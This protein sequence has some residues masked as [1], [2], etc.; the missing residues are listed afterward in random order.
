M[1][2]KRVSVKHILSILTVLVVLCTL[3]TLAGCEQGPNAVAIEVVED[4]VPDVATIGSFDLSQLKLRITDETGNTQEIAVT[5]SMLDTDSRNSLKEPG[6]KNINVFY[7]GCATT[8]NIFLVEEG[9][10][11]VSV[12]F[13]ARDFTQIAKKHTVANGSIEAPQAPSIAGMVFDCW[14]NK[15][16]S[17]EASFTNITS[18]LIVYA[19]YVN[20]ENAAKY[21]VTFRDYTNQVI[22]I[23]EIPYNKTIIESGYTAPGWEE[24]ADIESWQWNWNFSTDRV[25]QNTNINMTVTY[26]SRTIAFKY[27]YSTDINNE[28]QFPLTTSAT[29]RIGS[30]PT[31]TQLNAAKAEL[32]QQ[33]KQFVSWV[34]M[35]AVRTNTSNILFALVQ[36]TNYTVSFT[37]GSNETASVRSGISYTMPTNYTA[38]PGYSFELKWKDAQG[39]IYNAG[40]SYVINGNLALTPVYTPEVKNAQFIFSFVGLADPE[41]ESEVLTYQLDR[42][43]YYD[44]VIRRDYIAGLLDQL[45]RSHTEVYDY[46]IDIIKYFG[47]TVTGN[48]QKIGF[49]DNHVFEITCVDVSM[50]SPG[51]SFTLDSVRNGYV[52][53]GYTPTDSESALN[54]I[55][56]ETYDGLPVIGIADGVFGADVQGV[57]LTMSISLPDG[58][59]FI[60]ENA[61]EGVT[62][63]SDV[64]IPGSLVEMGKEAFLNA[65]GENIKVIFR[66]SVPTSINEI[67]ESAFKSFAGLK[68]VVLPRNVNIIG[69]SAFAGCANLTK[70][71]LADV[72]TIGEA[73]FEGCSALNDIG[74]LNTVG[75]VGDYAFAGTAL[76]SVFLPNVST[77]GNMVFAL[78]TKLAT[79]SIGTGNESENITFDFAN[80]MGSSVTSLTLGKGVTDITNTISAKYGYTGALNAAAVYAA[81]RL[82]TIN[83]AKDIA[84]D[85][86]AF[87]L[88]PL[89]KTITVEAGSAYS[90]QNFALFQGD[91]LIYYPPCVY[92]DYTVPAT[93]TEIAENALVSANLNKLTL[94]AGIATVNATNAAM[95][96]V[97]AMPLSV[98]ETIMGAALGEMTATDILAALDAVFKA[99]ATYYINN[100]DALEA[101]EK[102]EVDIL[103]ADESR[104]F[105]KDA[106]A[107]PTYYDAASKLLYTFDKNNIATIIG[108]D[109]TASA[110][111]IP[112]TINGYTVARLGNGAFSGYAYLETLTINATLAN[113]SGTD[114]FAGCVSLSSV[115][116]AGLTERNNINYNL[117]NDTKL[118]KQRVVIVLAGVPVAYNANYKR[119]LEGGSEETVT[120]V[121][122]ADLSGATVIPLRFFKDCANLTAIELPSTVTAVMDNAFENCTSLT[123]INLNNVASVGRYAFRGCTSL[124][125]VDIPKAINAQSAQVGSGKLPVGIFYGC[126][127]LTT[128]NMPNVNGFLADANGDSMAFY[129]CD[130]L[131]DVSFLARFTGIIYGKAF[132]DCDA[133]E[134]FDIS[135][136]T[137]T[138]IR[139]QAFYGC[140][141]LSYIVLGNVETLGDE[142]FNQNPPA[143]Q[144]VRIKGTGGIFAK[145][146]AINPDVFPE[147]VMFYIDANLDAE[148][149]GDVLA[150]YSYYRTI[151]PRISF[152][153]L[154]GFEIGTNQLGMVPV[155]TSYMATAPVAPTFEGY[156]FVDWFVDGVKAAFPRTFYADTVLKAKYYSTSRGSVSGTDLTQ[157]GD[158]YQL[159]SYASNDDTSYIPSTYI[160]NDGIAR[161]IVAINLAA[162]NGKPITSLV[163]PEGVLVLNG[164][165]GNTNITSIRI[166]SSVE[167]ITAAD[168]F[169]GNSQLDIVWA[170]GSNLT[171]A[172]ASAFLGTKWYNEAQLAAARGYNNRFVVAGRMAIKYV[173]AGT[174]ADKTVV[175]PGQVIMLADELFKD[176]T[177]ITTVTLNDNL[178][179]IGNNA[180]RNA[181]NLATINYE[182]VAANSAVASVNPDYFIGTKW[183]TNQNQ[184]VIGTMFLKYNGLYAV[185]NYSIP[186]HIV[187]I[188]RNAFKNAQIKT[189]TFAGNKVENIGDNAFE[190][191][192]LTSITLPASIKQMGKGVFKNCLDLLTANLSGAKVPALPDETFQGCTSLR[193]LTLGTDSKALGNNSLNNCVALL[194]LTADGIETSVDPLQS[195]LSTTAWYKRD[196]GNDDL[197]IILGKVYLKYKMGASPVLN[198]Q[199]LVEVTIPNNVSIISQLAFANISNIG[200]VTIPASVTVIE[201]NAFFDC[202][203]LIQV[204]FAGA[205]KLVEIGD[206]AFRGAS[207]LTDV[208]LPQGLIEIGEY[209]FEGAALK[210]VSI[211]DSV[212]IIKGH[213]FENAGLETLVLGKGLIYIGEGAFSENDD[214][215]KAEWELETITVS[216]VEVVK[217]L[218][219]IYDAAE[220]FEYGLDA[221][222]VD[223][224]FTRSGSSLKI[225]LYVP[226]AAFSVINSDSAYVNIWKTRPSFDFVI[227]GNL[228]KVEFDGNGYI[229]PGFNT[230]LIESLPTPLRTDHTF[231]YWQVDGE[232][233]PMVFP[234]HVKKDT[235]ITAV[236]YKNSRSDNEAGDILDYAPNMDGQGNF[237]SY[238]IT[239]IASGNE[240]VYVPNKV[241]SLPVVGFDLVPGSADGVKK[242]VF[243]QASNLFGITTNIFR[244]FTNLESVEL[245]DSGTN[246]VV[247]K[248]Q[249]GAMYSIDGKELI[250]YFIQR[251]PNGNVKTSFRV[252]EGVTTIL[253][254]A[255]VNGGLTSVEL[256]TVSIKTIGEYA[257]GEDTASITF[258]ATQTNPPAVYITDAT[259]ESVE[260]TAW[261]ENGVGALAY[262]Y[263]GGTA[264]Y[265][266]ALGNILLTYHEVS[267]VNILNL[268]NAVNGINITVL[269]SNLYVPD[270]GIARTTPFSKIVLPAS[271]R[272]INAAA[273]ANINALDFDGA[274][275]AN[276]LVDIADDVFSETDYYRAPSG[277]DNLIILGKVLLL[278]RGTAS[279]LDLNTDAKHKA[280]TTIASKAFQGSQLVSVTLPGSLVNISDMAFYSSTQLKTVTIPA[281][282][283]RIGNEAF[284]NCTALTGITFA[285]NSALTEIGD[286]AFESCYMLASIAV[287]YTVTKIGDHAFDTCFALETVT[288][289]KLSV[290]VN[291]DNSTTVT[292]VAKSLLTS[293]GVSAFESCTSLTTISI[294]DGITEIK[295]STFKDCT[296]LIYVKFDTDKSKVKVI[297]KQAFY[298]CVSLGGTLDVTDVNNVNLVTVVLPN[299]LVRVEDEAFANCSGLYGIQFN[300]NIREI[301]RDVFS[302]DVKLTKLVIYADTPPTIASNALTREKGMTVPYYR[303][304]IYVKKVNNDKV[305]ND[306][307]TLWSA[308]S[309]S[310]YRMG[311][312]P[313]LTFRYV[314]AES[315]VEE[316]VVPLNERKDVYVNKGH[317][318][319]NRVV[320]T[321]WIFSKVGGDTIDSR[322]NTVLG[323][324]AYQRQYNY[325]TNTNDIILIMDTDIE[326]R[327]AQ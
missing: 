215:Y 101:G 269:A 50:G 222:F 290:T 172:K 227:T 306:Y 243:T 221:E 317:E 216:G 257:F 163:I 36:S 92:G 28:T 274:A 129:D 93:I 1:K 48:G 287:P 298:N 252:P 38:K 203:S 293:L 32:A 190:G 53:T 205:S 61:F 138:E 130:S 250:A 145:K 241:N 270:S 57:S 63:S 263:N 115:T 254:Y 262:T 26:K 21:T 171:D 286:G 58:L 315:L 52:I 66:A 251:D 102:T 112:A 164:K 42:N 45:K 204:V 98:M 147:D 247:Y 245:L 108:G 289:D 223:G 314:M 150:N 242:I 15:N 266:Y 200:K 304:R 246:N 159:S 103:V 309:S 116:L 180:F 165:L 256:P 297:G 197:H 30:V 41:D 261:Y 213:A 44:D 264:G 326:L 137:I 2:F 249:N 118:Y 308:Y 277:N 198:N 182:S 124:E 133:I 177:A 310:I 131:K 176:N 281:T 217:Q 13:L 291:P 25:T 55:I 54:V 157:Y 169:A 253:P 303:L 155:S 139:A 196:P 174:D 211:P 104:R 193:T 156:V 143:L 154:E 162:F 325:S 123:Y 238:R 229:M 86:A 234:Y 321:N 208:I 120:V 272:K 225:R 74:N 175:I 75:S 149:I 119:T 71:N 285:A 79:L 56:P 148:T 288:F 142:A 167:T 87:N 220:D 140:D 160:G 212:T 16:N 82:N 231:M 195:G 181:T 209:A 312:Y 244:V 324:A 141:S 186:A 322:V 4:S 311:E 268:P 153:V 128:V 185:D 284:K 267:E 83:F 132:Y 49:G 279:T 59:L 302:G 183:Y 283:T 37:D 202:S 65:S 226:A 166:A 33:G 51:L 72:Q 110:I 184:L 7:K 60:G 170:S 259:R 189:V 146:V 232:E 111:T 188:Y 8:F 19:Y 46:D 64:S 68:E 255:F 218:R 305:Y 158:G 97:V 152:S 126:S 31:D 151:E 144:S 47:S 301:G 84:I 40:Q 14:R 27:V 201:A 178:R 320:V 273:F 80:I 109:R 89:M 77:L 24:P 81:S 295:E 70:I 78:T 35:D 199:G 276:T 94:H 248:V 105:I 275:A 34:N 11:T 258:Y 6:E 282:V 206:N 88:F 239:G 187:T 96:N 100:F 192:K 113:L 233:G 294:P 20:T 39:N 99:G 76:V 313:S 214:L 107:V 210:S 22:A 43:V 12:T 278:Y 237:I 134:S 318:F 85:V 219:D 194:N 228:P 173:A 230:E 296:N 327:N 117:F 121:T 9:T 73:A 292:I 179:I 240:T 135:I 265:F 260:N 5:L 90:V 3:L 18:D 69:D 122:A 323:S 136:S 299:A 161:R 125:T 271:L 23:Y 168:A 127:A 95:L 300:Y 235:T 10:Q 91:A 319:S 29:V 280:I 307:R 224:I 67:P 106:S 316:F 17:Q 114:I 207:N 236:W 62:F 191:S